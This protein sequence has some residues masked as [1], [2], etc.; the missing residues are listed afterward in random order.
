MKITLFLFNYFLCPMKREFVYLLALILRLGAVE[1]R[2]KV[3]F[4]LL[5]FLRNILCVYVVFVFRYRSSTLRN[6]I[7]PFHHAHHAKLTMKQ[8]QHMNTMAIQFR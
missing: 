8:E 3:A 5:Q 1:R 4:P 7:L 2:T 6:L